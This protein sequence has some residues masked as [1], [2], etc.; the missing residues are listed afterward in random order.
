[1]TAL[2]PERALIRRVSPFAVP[3]AVIAFAGGALLGGASAGWSSAIAVAIVYLNFV[4]NALSIAW[5]A[6]ISP[7]LVS[8]VALAGYVVRLIVYTIALVLLNQLSWFSPVAFALT[9]VPAVIALLVYEAKALSG[10]MQAD[11]WTFD[12][13]GRP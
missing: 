3:A 11:L 12:G 8:I 2:E 9:L 10:R 1:V 13:A 5:A 6:S 4:A 7:T